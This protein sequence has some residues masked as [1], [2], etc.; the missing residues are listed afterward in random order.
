MVRHLKNDSA[1]KVV[2]HHAADWGISPDHIGFLGISAGAM[3]ASAALLQPDSSLR[4][5]FAAPIY[6]GPFGKMP[7]IPNDLP[8]IF[9]AWAQDD[10][11]AAEPVAKFYN[12]LKAAGN[13]PEAHIYS[14][15]H[16]GFGMKKQGTTS[17]HW[18]NEF[19][20]WLLANRFAK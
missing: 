4:P 2:R 9:M 18:I 16:H 10:E 13:K 11:V 17:D 5:N 3:V 6:G 15:G 19:Y 8:P 12:A 7:A 20:W 14:S 1:V